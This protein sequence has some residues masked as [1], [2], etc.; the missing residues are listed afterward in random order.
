LEQIPIMAAQAQ[1]RS[2]PESLKHLCRKRGGITGCVFG[3]SSEE[4]AKAYAW[5]FATQKP[6][7]AH[8]L[9]LQISKP[10]LPGLDTLEYG[11]LLEQWDSW[12]PFSFKVL[13]G[14]YVEAEAAFP[15]ANEDDVLVWQHVGSN[16]PLGMGTHSEPIGLPK[17]LSVLSSG[18]KEPVA[19]APA[20]KKAKV[21]I[22]PAMLSQF[23][24]LADLA[25]E[26][27]GAAASSHDQTQEA[28]EAEDSPA[29]P[30][31]DEDTV[32]AEAWENLQAQRLERQAAP[33]PEVEDFETA[34]QSGNWTWGDRDKV[35][36]ACVARAKPGAPKQWC[37]QYSLPKFASFSCELHG[38][39]TAL[40]FSMEWCARMQHY[41]D[42]RRSQLQGYVYTRADKASY[43][44]SQ[45]WI[46]LVHSLPSV[47]KARDRANAIESLFPALPA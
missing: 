17:F 14:Q 8:F 12:R 39:E 47:G 37:T 28:G 2:L 3:T 7:A 19:K 20:A 33:L 1:A 23:P 10:A 27:Q 34:W 30:I 24:W 5:L 44:P 25:Q 31:V 26:S 11:E 18:D 38:A 40:A 13:Y 46:D 43:K 9:A 6:L 45:A 36:D 15:G 21:E 22:D 42:L 35:Y 32:I 29:E 41:Y 16:P 4:G